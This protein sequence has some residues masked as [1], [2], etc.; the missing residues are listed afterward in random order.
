MNLVPSLLIYNPLEA[1][2]IILLLSF[3]SNK[4]LRFKSVIINSYILG[5]INLIFQFII[6]L[7]YGTLI[8][9]MLT[10]LLQFII[11]P[12]IL[13]IYCSFV[14]SI[15][16]NF[17]K[18]YIIRILFSFSTLLIILL[19]N[20]LCVFNIFINCFGICE[21]LLLNLSVR[22]SQFIILGVMNF[23]KRRYNN[24]RIPK[25]TCRK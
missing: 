6:E 16:I 10:T 5:T 8:Y 7:N 11:L 9:S 25:E 23:I 2:V 17:L 12:Y 3:V 19:L 24:E 20:K 14:M 21:E 22:V 1:L 4:R 18:V 15:K 13:Y